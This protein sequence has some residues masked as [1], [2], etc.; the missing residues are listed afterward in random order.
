MNVSMRCTSQT[1]AS[2]GRSSNRRTLPRICTIMI[3]IYE[4]KSNRS[5]NLRDTSSQARRRPRRSCTPPRAQRGGDSCC[6]SCSTCGTASEDGSAPRRGT[7]RDRNG[8]EISN[9]SEGSE[10]RRQC[11]SGRGEQREEEGKYLARLREGNGK[12]EE[13]RKDVVALQI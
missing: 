9:Q 4:T 11:Q 13:V 8:D 7:R 6:P 2:L 5:M 1:A 3:S 12:V 10:R